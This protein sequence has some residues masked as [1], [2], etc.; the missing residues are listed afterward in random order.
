MTNVA[1]VIDRYPTDIHPHLFFLEGNEILFFAS[2]SVI[3][4]KSHK[5]ILNR[6]NGIME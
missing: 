3:D 6:N 4:A 2:Q 1:E 5:S